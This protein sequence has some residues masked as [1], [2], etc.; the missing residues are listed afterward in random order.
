VYVVYQSMCQQGNG[1]WHTTC[2]LSFVLRKVHCLS[3]TSDQILG[4]L[5]VVCGSLQSASKCSVSRARSHT[6]GALSFC[7]WCQKS[8]EI[9]GLG[10]ARSRRP[11]GSGRSQSSPETCRWSHGGAPGLRQAVEIRGA[12]AGKGRA[13]P[14]CPAP[15]A[16]GPGSEPRLASRPPV[17]GPSSP[18]RTS[19]RPTA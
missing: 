11:W 14:P 1:T 16:S 13:P 19:A 7:R 8:E 18:A 15:G 4:R 2:H 3:L 6:G 9:R 17:G 10:Q 12:D 5:H